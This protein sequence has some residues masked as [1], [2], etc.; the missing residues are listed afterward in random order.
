[1]TAAA[2]LAG[3]LASASVEVSSRGNQLQELSAY[4]PAGIDVSI[5]FLPGD[6]YRHN[7]ETATALRRAGFNPVP[8]VAA[9]ELASREMLDDFLAR[10]RGEADVRRVLLI[11]GDVAGAR[12]PYKSSRD[13]AASG[14]LQTHGI[15]SV[16][17]AGYP[18]GHPY[19]E[20]GQVFDAL[21]A[22]RDWG[23]TSGIRVDVMTQFCFESAPI[24]AW[25]AELRAR[26][27]EL[28]V[29]VGLAGPAT[30]ATLTK[31]GLR[32]GVGNSMRA[33]RGQIGRFGRLLTDNGPDDVVRGLLTAAQDAT[34]PISGF[35]LFPFGGLRKSGTW[36]REVAHDLQ[37]AAPRTL[38]HRV[39]P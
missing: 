29:A 28:A 6:N 11:A 33:L 2:P 13:V 30:L 31:F 34:A 12:G 37:S 5:T 4:F 10:A 27:I 8:H 14:L 9:R 24:L 16:S 18:E 38:E 25:I 21:A 35:H 15:A 20:G 22:W 32:C 7:I 19:L 36:L 1:M 17:V 3:L 23:R 26:G 39:K